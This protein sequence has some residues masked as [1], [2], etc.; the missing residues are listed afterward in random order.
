MNTR[1]I[2]VSA[3]LFVLASIFTYLFQPDD[4]AQIERDI[5]KQTMAITQSTL[6]TIIGFEGFKNRAYKDTEGYYTIGVGHLIKPDEKSL[7]KATLTEEQV[8][9]L[10]R[11]DLSLCEKTIDEVVN[12]P[13]NQN[14]Y[15]A[16][17]SLCFNIGVPKFRTSSVVRKL[18]AGDYQGAAEAIL[19]WNKPEV[20]VKRRK[21]EKAL[22]LAAL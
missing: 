5:I 4:V 20:L 21:A 11:H 14:Q 22:F 1:A 16:L 15:D 7:I 2:G 10:L 18:N 13:L 8:H 3:Y 6:K 19:L 12:V 9:D 17:Y